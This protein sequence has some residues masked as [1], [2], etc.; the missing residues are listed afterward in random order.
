MGAGRRSATSRRLAL[1]AAT[2]LALVAGLATPA[3]GQEPDPT[4]TLA[5]TPSTDL[6]DNDAVTVSGTG[7]PAASEVLLYVCTAAGARCSGKAV[8]PADAAGGFSIPYRVR[9]IWPGSGWLDCRLEPCVL[10]ALVRGGPRVVAPLAFDPDEP[11]HDTATATATPATG[12]VD[13]QRVPLSGVGWEPGGHVEM[14]LC[15]HR[16]QVCDRFGPGVDAGPDGSFVGELTVRTVIVDRD[17]EADCRLVAC[18]IRLGD[19]AHVAVVPVGFDPLAPVLDPRLSVVPDTGLVNGQVVRVTGSGFVPGRELLMRRL[20][21]QAPDCGLHVVPDAD[22]RFAVD[23]T[24]QDV[25]D[26]YHGRVDCRGVGRCPLRVVEPW[27]WIEV[28]Q[29]PLSVLPEADEEVTVAPSTGLED[30]DVVRV[31]AVGLNRGH[32][33]EVNECVAVPGAYVPFPNT[34]WFCAGPEQT[35]PVDDAGEVH[36][37]LRVRESWPSTTEDHPQPF[38]CRVDR[39]RLVVGGPGIRVYVGSVFSGIGTY[40]DRTPLDF[41]SPGVP[42]TATVASPTFA[43]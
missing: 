42:V 31:D 18:E 34:R 8:V 38:D 13:G 25:I 15:G 17:G 12:L 26:V 9:A 41:V 14:R 6:V 36:T 28:A 7:W 35:L 23:Y 40:W 33:V 29:A 11:L 20:C 16:S 39:C 5:V 30:G 22:G 43:G 10:L 2:A 24:V 19:D 21:Y 27:P 32:S 3:A 37:M 1:V 4:P